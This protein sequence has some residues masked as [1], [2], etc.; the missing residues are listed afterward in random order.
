MKKFVLFCTLSILLMGSGFFA[1]CSSPQAQE[2][3]APL[4]IKVQKSLYLSCAPIFIALEEGYF[5]EQALEVELVPFTRSSEAIPAI[6]QGDLDVLGGSMSLGFLNAI[7]QNATLK[8]VADKGNEAKEHCAYTAIITRNDLVP[9]I[10]SLAD[11]KGRNVT[12]NEANYEG[13]MWTRLLQT[14]GLTLKDLKITDVESSAMLDA[15][16][17]GAIDFTTT[18]EPWLTRMLNSGDTQVWHS[19]IEII[20]DFQTAVL[21]FGP[22]F[23]EKNRE[24]GVRFMI[25]YLKGVRQYRQ[26]K[27]DRNLEIVAKYTQ[28]ETDLLKEVCWPDIHADGSINAESLVGYQDWGLS[29]GLLVSMVDEQQFW[30]PYFINKA[31]QELGAP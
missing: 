3:L 12:L 13:Y 9:Q 18:A 28:L 17:G 26:G 20:P 6:V 27:T 22:S 30:E 24:A 19:A 5:N 16:M 25:S 4:K 11:L 10:A 21:L 7:A 14:A 15:L 29:E 8:I 23:L 2:I 31:N 1:G